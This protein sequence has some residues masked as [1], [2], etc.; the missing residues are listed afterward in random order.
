MTDARWR[1]LALVAVAIT[2]ALFVLTPLLAMTGAPVELVVALSNVGLLTLV[3][4]FVLVVYV[5]ARH[6]G[7]ALWVGTLALAAEIAAAVLLLIQEPQP[8]YLHPEWAWYWPVVNTAYFGGLL[9]A[10]AGVFASAL[11][12]VTVRTRGVALGLLVSLAA[13]AI[14]RIAPYR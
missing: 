2:I 10:L 6:S 7:W 1:S 9:L 8:A 5:A 3:A 14:N 12:L 4:A 11:H 13:L